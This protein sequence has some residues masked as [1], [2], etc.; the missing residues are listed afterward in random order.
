MRDA[1]APIGEDDLQAFIDA[2]LDDPRRAAVEAYLAEHPEIAARVESERRQRDLLRE[3][4]QPKFDEPIPAHLRIDTLAAARRERRRGRWQTAAAACVM[5]V[6]GAGSGWFAALDAR[7]V[8]EPRPMPMVVADQA[9]LAYS[10]FASEVMHPVEVRA[11]EQAHLMTWLS[12]R[13][14]HAISAP[15]LSGHGYRLMGGRLLPGGSGAAAQLMYDDDHGNRLTLFVEAAHGD[16]TAFRFAQDRDMATFVW[17]DKGMGFAVTAKTPRDALLPI[18][19]AV[20]RQLDTAPRP[21][22]NG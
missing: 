12:K 10:T 1:R 2:R 4:L 6:V 20:Y 13:L 21:A 5:F 18:A 22:Q 11:T 9:T 15:D 3:L 14:G 16:T 7:P 19:E 17:I 8:A